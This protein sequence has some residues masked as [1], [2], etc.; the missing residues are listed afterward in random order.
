MERYF[1]TIDTTYINLFKRKKYFAYFSHK[2]A[3]SKF[4]LHLF[5]YFLY[6][7]PIFL[8]DTTCIYTKNYLLLPNLRGN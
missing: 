2:N 3:N 8:F 5:L 7:F 4:I 1:T 6:I